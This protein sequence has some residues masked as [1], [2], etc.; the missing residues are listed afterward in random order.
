[1]IHVYA[2]H[3][4][5]LKLNI[6]VIAVTRNP[7]RRFVSAYL[8]KMDPLSKIW[9]C[10]IM[11]MHVKLTIWILYPSAICFED[12]ERLKFWRRCPL[13]KYRP[14]AFMHFEDFLKCAVEQMERGYY[15]RHWEPLLRRCD[16]C[17]WPFNY[18]GNIHTP[19][20]L[21]P[22][23]FSLPPSSPF[24][25]PSLPPL[26]LSIFRSPYVTQRTEYINTLTI[27]MTICTEL[28]L[29]EVDQ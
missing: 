10:L 3:H 9:S 11:I 23:L 15:N 13:V 14:A 8:E 28:N 1:M 2:V 20:L 7:W 24:L 19:A 25:P 12:M 4:L 18:V 21:S 27:A 22:S 17:K 29:V 6:T 26:P 16:V 5:C